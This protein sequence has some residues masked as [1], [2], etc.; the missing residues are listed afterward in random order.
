MTGPPII[1]S[2][3]ATFCH[4]LVINGCFPSTF[5]RISKTCHPRWSR[6][7]SLQFPESFALFCNYP[8]Y[9]TKLIDYYLLRRVCFSSFC[10]N[11]LTGTHDTQQHFEQAMNEVEVDVISLPRAVDVT[12]VA[13]IVTWCGRDEAN[14]Q[15]SLVHLQTSKS[16]VDIGRNSSSTVLC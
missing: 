15:T 16:R 12:P 8:H 2:V 6:C 11:V 7:I 5:V 9:W 4:M 14:K 13:V 3:T 10:S 1:F